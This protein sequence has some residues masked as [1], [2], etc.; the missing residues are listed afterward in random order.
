[1]DEEG[2]T[3][4]TRRNLTLEVDLDVFLAFSEESSNFRRMGPL[5]LCQTEDEGE[6]NVLF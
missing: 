3:T 6:K 4:V 2:K 5:C 1:M